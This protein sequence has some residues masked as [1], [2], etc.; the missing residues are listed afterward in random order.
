VVRPELDQLPGAN[1]NY[2]CV[3]RWCDLSNEQFGVTWVTLDAN[4][5][6]FA[7]IVYTPAWGLEPWRS[8]IDPGGTLY[9]WVCNNHWETNYKAGQEGPLSFRY[10]LRPHAGPY[11]QATVQRFARGVHQPLLAFASDGTKPLANSALSLDND[12]V[13]ATCLKP[14]RDGT[15]LVLRLFNTTD[16]SQ[17]IAVQ[18]REDAKGSGFEPL[19]RE[20]GGSSGAAGNGEV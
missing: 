14:T 9:S 16:T 7:P 1:R 5:M 2:Y 18:C 10:V 6:Q 13:I 20:T 11:D 4:M 8:E 12:A 17:N 3:Q 19:G 15:G